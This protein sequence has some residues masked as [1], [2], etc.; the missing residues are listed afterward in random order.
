MM[1]TPNLSEL[2]L[3]QGSAKHERVV[4]LMRKMKELCEKEEAEDII[5]ALINYYFVVHHREN[6]DF[7]IVEC[8]IG[9]CV[10]YFK[11]IWEK[12]D[13]WEYP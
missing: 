6:I 13:E 3:R 4:N 7:N 8:N 9:N 10:Y 12:D 11:E 5:T 1:N 2:I